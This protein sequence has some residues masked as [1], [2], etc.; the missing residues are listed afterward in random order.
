[1]IKNAFISCSH[2]LL[3][4]F[5]NTKLFDEL[6]MQSTF[7]LPIQMRMCIEGHIN[8]K[9]LMRYEVGSEDL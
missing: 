5:E 3:V 1:M 6:Q 4:N 2:P 9:F 7:E 8:I